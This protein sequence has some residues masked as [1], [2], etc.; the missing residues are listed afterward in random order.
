MN[1]V[2]LGTIAAEFPPILEAKNP[3]NSEGAFLMLQ[4]GRI[5]FVYGRFKGESWADHAPADICL[6]TSE[7]GG[8]SFGNGRI[9]LTCE[10]E[11]AVNIM[12]L[13]LMKMSNG[14]IGL[15]YLVRVTYTL[16]Q[17]YLRRSSD[18]GQTWSERVLCTPQEGFFVVNNDRVTRLSDGRIL[19]PAACHRTGDSFF[20]S[21]SEVVFFYSDD[22]GATW[23]CS[24]GF[25]GGRTPYVM[26]VSRDNGKSFSEPA[27]FETDENSGYCYCAILF[28]EEAMLLGYNAGG[29]EDGSCLARTRI[30]WIPLAQLEKIE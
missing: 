20:D 11:K 1:R 13:S 24:E 3:R 5:I 19:I 7:D 18:G 15:F 16:M 4:D 25:T 14:D 27:A 30:R 8:R 6:V 10:E 26:A 23:N 2:E 12:S 28:T 17:L 29:P 22:D 21:R 9:V